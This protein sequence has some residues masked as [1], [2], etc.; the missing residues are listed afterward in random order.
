MLVD[1]DPRMVQFIDVR[2]E[3]LF[4]RFDSEN[5]H[6]SSRAFSLMLEHIEMD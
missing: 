2:L 6:F 3:I 4:G 1:L 5:R